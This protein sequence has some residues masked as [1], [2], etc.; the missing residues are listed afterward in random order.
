MEGEVVDFSSFAR[1]INN[2]SPFLRAKRAKKIIHIQGLKV[3]NVLKT[4]HDLF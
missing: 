4:K 1:K 2:F 3:K